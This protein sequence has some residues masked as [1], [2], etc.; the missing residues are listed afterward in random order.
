MTNFERVINLV[1][2]MSNV[3]MSSNDGVLCYF[4][5]NVDSYEIGTEEVSVS[6]LNG[7]EI[8]IRDA[9]IVKV[10]GR[11]VVLKNYIIAF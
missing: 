6:D 4:R 2:Q 1:G 10:D 7:N 8:L 11:Q 5:F 3:T 9:D